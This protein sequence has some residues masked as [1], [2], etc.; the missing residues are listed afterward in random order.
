[1]RYS[2]DA[3]YDENSL[4]DL[5]VVSTLGLT[6]EDE[7]ALRE[8]DGIEDAEGAYF[9]DVTCG[10][11]EKQTVLHIESLTKRVNQLTVTEGRLPQEIWRMCF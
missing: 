9:T 10:E 8:I 2:G 1:M 5:K 7:D 6:S 3:Y 4:M 11:N